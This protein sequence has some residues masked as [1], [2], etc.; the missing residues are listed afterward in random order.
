M[1]KEIQQALSTKHTITSESMKTL[2]HSLLKEELKAERKKERKEKNNFSKPPWCKRCKHILWEEPGCQ[3]SSWEAAMFWETK[4][5]LTELWSCPSEASPTK[6]HK[7]TT[8]C[9]PQYSLL[10][11]PNAK[12]GTLNPYRP[13]GLPYNLQTTPCFPQP[14]R[15][16][17]QGCGGH[18][19]GHSH[20]GFNSRQGRGQGRY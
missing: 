3:R 9:P 17:F 10:A 19:K 13:R 6:T 1:S 4:C 16:S 8:T 11:V 5:K 2:K 18:R 14:G 7:M 12:P 15:S 20:Q